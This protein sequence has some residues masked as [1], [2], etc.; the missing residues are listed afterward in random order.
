[1]RRKR[2][3]LAKLDSEE[4]NRTKAISTA[5]RDSGCE[6]I[7]LGTGNTIDHIVN[8]ALQEDADA[9]GVSLSNYKREILP[10]LVSKLEE[11][12]VNDTTIFAEGNIPNKDFKYLKRRGLDK[13]FTLETDIKEIPKY[14]KTIERKERKN[15]FQKIYD[16]FFSLE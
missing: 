9:I 6:V 3:I 4:D 13:L 15:F 10:Q 16:I 12:N 8:A 2:I 11:S 5:L 1:M 7:Y 14:I